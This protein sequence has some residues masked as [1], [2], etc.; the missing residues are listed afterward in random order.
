MKAISKL[1]LAVL[2]LPLTAI[3][4]KTITASAIIQ[5]INNHVA[6]D[7]AN[8]EITGDLDLTKL[9]NMKPESQQASSDKVY[10][11]TV[12]SSISFTNCIFKGKV[13]GYY[14]PDE[15]RNFVKSSTVYNTN[16]EAAVGFINCAFEKNV[17]CKYSAFNDKVSFAGS[18]FNDE[19][20]FKYAKFQQ[21]PKF[22]GAT[23]NSD[24]VF[25]YVEFPAGFDF[26]NT[27][28]KGNADFK[29]T[30]F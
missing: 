4:Q 15:G 18:R 25:K 23:F 21:G 14:N 24:A 28:F 19:A 3:A 12:T 17:A 29:Y 11:S 1:L 22:N 27:T 7:L 10:I 30:K 26:S 16:F 5:N 6:V 13:L 9:D 20:L 8:T 2:M